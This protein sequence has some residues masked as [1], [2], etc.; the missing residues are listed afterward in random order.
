MNDSRKDSSD[1]KGTE[2]IDDSFEDIEDDTERLLINMNRA[3]AQNLQPIR[4]LPREHKKSL[5]LRI[6]KILMKEL[7]WS[8]NE[9]KI[10]KSIIIRQNS[11]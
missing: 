8:L 2:T 11:L 10:K 3:K 7:L 1:R 4:K 5:K 6:S 9:K